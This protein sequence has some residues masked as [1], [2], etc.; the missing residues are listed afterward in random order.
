MTD[1]DINFEQSPSGPTKYF[2]WKVMGTSPHESAPLF[3]GADSRLSVE[4][5]VGA[6]HAMP[7][8]GIFLP[9]SAQ[10]VL[11]NYNYHDYAALIKYEF[12]EADIV[13]GRQSM[14]D[15]EPEIGVRRATVVSVDQAGY[16][17]RCRSGARGCS[18]A[19]IRRSWFTRRA[20]HLPRPWHGGAFPID[21]HY[22]GD[23][24]HEWC[25][26]QDSNLRHSDS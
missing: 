15:R 22:G 4:A 21:R 14:G 25:D 6:V 8:A 16:W 1:P 26:R 13:Y 19:L 18:N 5:R 3:S 23:A 12:D 7:G 2:G 10:Y 24:P 20:I 9:N 17:C 11:E